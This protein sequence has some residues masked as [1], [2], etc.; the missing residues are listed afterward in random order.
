[1]KCVEI[2][3]GKRDA[4]EIRDGNGIG[5]PLSRLSTLIDYLSTIGYRIVIL[6][7][8]R[9]SNNNGKNYNNVKSEEGGTAGSSCHIIPL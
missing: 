3:C 4:V 2:K 8:E 1:M 9:P 7:I 6:N 5:D